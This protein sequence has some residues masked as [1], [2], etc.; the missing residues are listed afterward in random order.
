[1]KIAGKTSVIRCENKRIRPDK[2]EVDHLQADTS[3]VKQLC[4]WSANI[5]FETGLHMTFEELKLAP[6]SLSSGYAV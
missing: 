4:N 1:M 2:S 6:P 3:K 5:D